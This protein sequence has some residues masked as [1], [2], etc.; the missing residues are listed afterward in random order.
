M[1]PRAV[2]SPVPTQQGAAWSQ[3]H[4]S[5]QGSSFPVCSSFTYLFSQQGVGQTE[6][7]KG[8]KACSAE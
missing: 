5:S 4:L 3:V 2:P 7:K 1:L 8:S 6:N